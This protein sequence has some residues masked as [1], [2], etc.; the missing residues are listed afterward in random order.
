[1]AKERPSQV[2]EDGSELA[3]RIVLLLSAL[4]SRRAVSQVELMLWFGSARGRTRASMELAISNGWIERKEQ[5]VMLL[6]AG[7]QMLR[8]GP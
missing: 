6:K 7:K 1:M 3:R 8:R 4:G 2:K 5:G